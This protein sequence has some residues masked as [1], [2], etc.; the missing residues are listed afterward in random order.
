MIEKEEVVR[1]S[2][3]PFVCKPVYGIR[4]PDPVDMTPLE[5]VFE[6]YLI[7]FRILVVS[8]RLR[9]GNDGNIYQ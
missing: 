7:I 5:S 6:G 8:C 1:C 3:P 2:Q 9:L 4:A